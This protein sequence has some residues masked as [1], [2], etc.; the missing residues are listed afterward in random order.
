MFRVIAIGWALASAGTFAWAVASP[1]YVPLPDAL[2][3]TERCATTACELAPHHTNVPVGVQPPA[4]AP[5]RAPVSSSKH[6]ASAT[7][8]ERPA[9]S[10][11]QLHPRSDVCYVLGVIK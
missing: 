5:P 6:V 2:P 9:A 4:P 1:D 7:G 10:C 11:A 8:A 3:P